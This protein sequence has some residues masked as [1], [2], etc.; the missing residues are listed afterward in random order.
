M[1]HTHTMPSTAATLPQLADPEHYIASRWNL[2]AD[3]AKRDYWLKLFATHFPTLLAEALRE[4]E[5]RGEDLAEAQARA[6]QAQHMFQTHLDQLAADPG[7]ERYFGIIDICYERERILRANGFADPYRL[8]KAR[9]NEA[10][11]PLLKPLLDE[12]DA[13]PEA[14]RDEAVVRGMFAGNIFDLGATETVNRF[15]NTRVDFHAIR[16]ELKPRPW[17]FDSLDAW[18]NRLH[19]GDPHRTA[20]LF[21]DN[22]GPDVVL[23]ML[24][25][26][27]YLLQRGT[28]VLLAANTAPSLNDVT[29]EELEALVA[30]AAAVDDRF[31]EAWGDGRLRVLADGNN[32]PLIDLTRLDP[33]FVTAV[34]EQPVDLVVL[35]GMGRAIESNFEAAFTCD[36]LK[37]AMIK[38]R[39]VA[40]A[41]EGDLYDLVLRFEPGRGD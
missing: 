37:V 33:A 16:G 5:S 20:L 28:N 31:A 2:N 10:A 34:S 19:A 35:E 12:L 41:L 18:R 3:E 32:A 11:L 39:G 15:T 26:A 14:E 25:F 27:R 29:A 21:V 38:D 17:L 9:E 30:Q 4:A 1:Q 24:P 23:G 6:Q 8:A 40:D 22:A 7:R 36:V 13:M